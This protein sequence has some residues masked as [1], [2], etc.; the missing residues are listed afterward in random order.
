MQ[1]GWGTW[2]PCFWPQP[3]V[4]FISSKFP[5]I[6]T[7]TL[8]FYFIQTFSC[9]NVSSKYLSVW[10]KVPFISSK[11]LD[12]MS[13]TLKWRWQAMGGG[14]KMASDGRGWQDADCMQVPGFEPTTAKIPYLWCLISLGI[15]TTITHYKS[16][17]QRVALLLIQMEKEK[18]V[19]CQLKHIISSL[20]D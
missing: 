3:N 13:I 4:L 8:S 10:S 19:P 16:E 5:S 14:D 12:P 11:G 15:K 2:N 17:L 7:Q 6:F 1:I 20:L 9:S 18:D